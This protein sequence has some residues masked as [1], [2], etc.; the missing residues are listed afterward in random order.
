MK[1]IFITL[2]LVSITTICLAGEFTMSTDTSNVS[3]GEMA[4]GDWKE[5]GGGT[6]HNQLTCKSTNGKTWYVKIYVLAPLTSGTKT[7][8]NSYF[9]YMPGWTNG[10]GSVQNQYSFIAFSGISSLV[11]VSGPDDNSGSDVYLQFKYGLS[12][13]ANQVAGI[14][15]TTVRYV[16][17]ETL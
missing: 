9:K 5:L 12:I 3:F 6:Y 14:Y 15:N 13:P 16:M 17:T 10:T 4:I 1:F 11:Y 2:L 8:N 7:I